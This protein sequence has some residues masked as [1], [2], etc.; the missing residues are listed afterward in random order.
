MPRRHS[1]SGIIFFKILSY[2]HICQLRSDDADLSLKIE[3]RGERGSEDVDNAQKI[4]HSRSVRITPEIS[5][6]III[7]ADWV[8]CDSTP[9][10]Y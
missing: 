9:F 5:S 4:F 6:L 2:R 1:L 3:E 8:R 10:D 7:R